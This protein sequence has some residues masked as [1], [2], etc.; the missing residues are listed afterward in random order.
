M[1]ALVKAMKT[2]KGSGS[3]NPV[4]ALPNHGVL[5]QGNVSKFT[6]EWPG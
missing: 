4:A 6:A 1:I 5:N 2:G 3:E